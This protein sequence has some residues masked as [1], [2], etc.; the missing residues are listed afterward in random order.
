MFQ[1]SYLWKYGISRRE[2][3]RVGVACF[4]PSVT[5]PLALAS[6]GGLLEPWVGWFPVVLSANS[7]H[8]VSLQLGVVWWDG[9]DTS[10]N[11]NDAQK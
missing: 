4:T 5:S 7:L 11:V 9:V 8:A 10:Y 2:S 3:P 1:L 6:A